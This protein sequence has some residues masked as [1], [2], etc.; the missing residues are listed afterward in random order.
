MVVFY[1]VEMFGLVFG[2]VLHLFWPYFAWLWASLHWAYVEW[3]LCFVL[4]HIFSPFMCIST[5]TLLQMVNHQNSWNLLV[6]SPNSKFGGQLCS[7][8]N[9]TLLLE[10]ISLLKLGNNFVRKHGISYSSFSL[11]QA[12]I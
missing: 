6:V 11:F 8:P 4:L 3:Y 1:A 7:Y 9:S 10:N 12:G 2:P 5:N